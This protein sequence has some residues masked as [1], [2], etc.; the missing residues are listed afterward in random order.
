MRDGRFG[1]SVPRQTRR[2][3]NRDRIGPRPRD[4]AAAHVPGRGPPGGARST[5]T[6][7]DPG[8]LDRCLGACQT[9]AFEP[10]VCPPP[11]IPPYDPA[12]N[13]A[14]ESSPVRFV[15][16]SLVAASPWQYDE[17]FV[18]SSSRTRAAAGLALTQSWADA[19][20]VALTVGQ[21]KGSSSSCSSARTAST[22][23]L[24][25]AA[26]T[27]RSD[28]C[29]SSR[30][31]GLSMH[32]INPQLWINLNVPTAITYTGGQL[33]NLRSR[34][35]LRSQTSGRHLLRALAVGAAQSA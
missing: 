29:I 21:H 17:I 31:A 7:P 34:H 30:Q 27:A 26:S 20:S 8:D 5:A 11:I 25:D 1:G 18:A 4:L 10:V 22:S 33:G 6:G 14:G 3:Q 28:L 24:V 2:I 13:R 16:E 32:Q 9:W 23:S 35:A 15:A 19:P 12:A